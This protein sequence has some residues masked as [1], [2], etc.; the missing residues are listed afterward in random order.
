MRRLLYPETTIFFI[1]F[2]I[3]SRASFDHVKQRFVPEI[4]KYSPNTPFILVGTKSDLRHSKK[5]VQQYKSI[6]KFTLYRILDNTSNMVTYAEAEAMAK[7]TS[8]IC[9]VE[10]SSINNSNVDDLFRVA[11]SASF[12]KNFNV[13]PSKK[14]C[15]VQ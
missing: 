12:M 9:Y 1:V 11:V 3:D 6:I 7:Q 2:A 14:D 5:H 13:V 15:C 8:A 10:T 4:H